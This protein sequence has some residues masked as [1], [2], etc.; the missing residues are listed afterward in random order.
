VFASFN[1]R[2]D[3]FFKSW[4]LDTPPPMNRAECGCSIVNPSAPVLLMRRRQ[5]ARATRHPERAP[6]EPLELPVVV[7]IS[8]LVVRCCFLRVLVVHLRATK[9]LEVDNIA[10]GIHRPIISPTNYEERRA[11]R[12]ITGIDALIFELLGKLDAH[13][14]ALVGLRR[15]DHAIGVLKRVSSR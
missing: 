14:N 1:S 9:Y 7:P 6:A 10:S 11:V 13:G 8:T 5:V 12:R 15:C 2:R 4:F 3:E